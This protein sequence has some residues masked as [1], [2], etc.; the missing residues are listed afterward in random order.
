MYSLNESYCI[1]IEILLKFGPKVA[2][3][4]TLALIQAMAW[5]RIDDK[6]GPGPRLKNILEI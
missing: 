1:L 5:R 6:S 2:V 3:K 4:N